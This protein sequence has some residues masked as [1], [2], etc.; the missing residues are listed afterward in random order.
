MEQPPKKPG[1][2]RALGNWRAVAI[3]PNAPPGEGDRGRVREIDAG[4]VV[5]ESDNL[6]GPG[7]RVRLVIMLS[8]PR[9]GAPARIVEVL[10][11]VAWSVI[12][13]DT[14]TTRLS[15][16]EFMQ[17]GHAALGAATGLSLGSKDG[18]G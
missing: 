14:V 4:G 2:K 12:V 6:M 9:H 17:G 3:A 1:L 11:K 15:F 18:P 10:S 7:V 13:R 16:V 8:P 5:F